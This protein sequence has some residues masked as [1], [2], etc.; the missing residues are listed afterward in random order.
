MLPKL[1]VAQNKIK[2]KPSPTQNQ[3]WV[4]SAKN[5]ISKPAADPAGQT[6][7][8]LGLTSAG[9]GLLILLQ[10]SALFCQLG[11]ANSIITSVEAQTG[12]AHVELGL[13]CQILWLSSGVPHTLSQMGSFC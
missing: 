6:P 1:F 2:H 10:F 9:I 3:N 12:F 8:G 4:R 7:A 13:F 11:L 5:A